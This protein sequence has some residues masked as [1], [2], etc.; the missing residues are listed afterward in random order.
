M[1][2]DVHQAWRRLSAAQLS[3]VTV[4][5]GVALIQVL[6]A[7]LFG[8]PLALAA[9]SGAVCTGLP[10]VPNPPHRVLGRVLPAVLIVTVVTLMVGLC[11]ETPLAMVLL[12]A[13]VAFVTLMAMAWGPRAGPLSFSGV[14]ALV[15]AMAWKAPPTPREALIHA[16][17]VLLGAALYV[18]WARAVAWWMRRRYRELALARAMRAC[19]QRLRSRAVRI[20]GEIASQDDTIRASIADDSEFAEALQAARD[21]VFAARFSPRSRRQIAMVLGLIELRDLLL[22]SRLDVHLLGDDAA[23]RHWRAGLAVT[24]RQ[25]AQTLNALAAAVDRGQPAPAVSAQAL[26]RKMEE[27]LAGGPA[28][29]GDPRQHL[30]DALQ[31]RLGHM[32]DD[33]AEMAES[34]TGPDRELPWSHEQLQLFVSPEGWPLAALKPHLSLQ[35]SVMRHALRGSLAMSFAY[36]LGL[37]LPWAAHPHWLVLSVAVVLRG[38]LEQTLSRRNDRIIGTVIGCLLAAA[39]AHL[40][41]W[42]HAPLLLEL[43]FLAAVGTSHA[44]VNQRYRVAATAATLMALMQPLLLAPQAGPAAAERL[45]DTVIGALLAWA[46][47]FVLPSWERNSQLRL[48]RQLAQALSRHAG[49]VLCWAPSREQQLAQRLSRQQAYT[50]L[51][52]MAAAAQRT[53][54]EP[55]Q[56]QVPEPELEAVLTHGYRFMALLGALQQM[57]SRRQG[58]LDAA[59]ARPALESARLHCTQALAPHGSK[60]GQTDPVDDSDVL[61][62][63]WPDHD[64]N[65]DVTPWLLRR[66]GIAGRASQRLAGALAALRQAVG[67][68][69]AA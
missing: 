40:E 64:S 69:Q 43:V 10:D 28:D 48:C 66:L 4:A 52:A 68:G 41:V 57:L 26:R 54:V 5:L 9:T 32:L 12:I 13:S 3:G 35:S 53:R 37:A 34:L 7:S 18:I 49:N 8:L 27:R 62:A 29:A 14:L 20:A 2:L 46:F 44:Y 19:A 16:A 50:A 61:S 65:A 31:V 1:R 67:K 59:Q 15:F 60:E 22:A 30:I 51:M 38:N 55:R 24:L 42:L 47:C 45:A 23:A 25:L 21:Q 6:V 17:W 56:V 11:R 58:Y 63:D 39:L 36:A 33:V